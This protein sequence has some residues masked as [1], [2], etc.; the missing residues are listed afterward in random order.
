MTSS[1]FHY[2]RFVFFLLAAAS[3]SI[4][5][6]I[7]Q[8]FLKKL[9]FRPKRRELSRREIRELLHAPSEKI[10]WS[11]TRALLALQDEKSL[12]RILESMSHLGRFGLVQLEPDLFEVGKDGVFSLE[13]ALQHPEPDVRMLA[14]GIAGRLRQTALIRFVARLLEDPILDVRMRALGALTEMSSP[15]GKNNVLSGDV[16]TILSGRLEQATWE[17][18]ARILQVIGAW[19]LKKFIPDVE[20]QVTNLH[21]WVRYRALET[22]LLLGAEGR[23]RA[24]AILS[25]YRHIVFPILED[26]DVRNDIQD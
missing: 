21:P 20:N 26:L 23:R 13:E 18:T 12:P 2:S 15:T 16:E 17:E 4:F 3:I 24:N 1:V 8:Q 22:L 7:V 6:F 5:L 10:R 14:L 25:E 19:K 11:A 9:L